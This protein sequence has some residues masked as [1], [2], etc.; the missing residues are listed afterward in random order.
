MT[1]TITP[2]PL[3]TQAYYILIELTKQD[4]RP[5]LL[6]TRLNLHLAAQSQFPDA[7]SVKQTLERLV[8]RGYVSHNLHQNITYHLEPGG[9]DALE[10]EME[11]LSGLVDAGKSALVT[12]RKISAN[13]LRG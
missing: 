1:R 13:R 5:Y 2:K 11:R 8:K 4:Y 6:A 7:S 12:A 3:T 10:A 9:Y